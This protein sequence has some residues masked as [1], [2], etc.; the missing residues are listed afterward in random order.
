[1]ET[2]SCRTHN[3]RRQI[4]ISDQFPAYPILGQYSR[5]GHRKRNP[6]HLLRQIKSLIK[7]T[8]M[9]GQRVTMIC[10]P[11]NQS[12]LIQMKLPQL[13]DHTSCSLV[14]HGNLSVAPGKDFLPSGPFHRIWAN[15]LPFPARFPSCIEQVGF[16]FSS[17]IISKAGI[18]FYGFRR[19]ER[20]KFFCRAVWLVWSPEINPHHKRNLPTPFFL[21]P[22]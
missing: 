11:D 1:M 13:L 14:N 8:A 9:T 6:Q 19:I 4:T 17:Q 16:R 2:A 15:Q 21:L 22:I 20:R 18:F 5:I 10:C 3:C 12:I 7:M